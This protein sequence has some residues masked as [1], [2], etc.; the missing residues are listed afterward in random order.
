MHDQ[1]QLWALAAVIVVALMSGVVFTR[2][3]QPALVGYL[4]SGILLGPSCL[5]VVESR[6]H[7]TF[8]ADLG[9]LLLLFIVGMELSL[10]SFR[11]VWF[12]A[13]ATAVLQIVGAIGI[14]TLVSAGLGWPLGRTILLGFVV[15]ISSTAVVIKI[16]EDINLLRTQI[17]Q[18]TVSILIAQDLA[19]VPMLLIIGVLTGDDV[20][21]ELELGK[22]VLSIALLAGL[23]WYLSRR[24]RVRLPFSRVLAASTE[25]RPLYGVALCFG[26]AT[27]TGALG[28]SSVYGAFLAGLIVGNSNAR[29]TL[30]HSVKPIQ[31]ILVMVFFVSIGLLIDLTFVWDN[32]GPVLLILF[33]VTIGKTAM[34]IGVLLVLRQPWLHAAISGLLLAQIGEFSFLLGG[35]GLSSGLINND[36]FQ[37]V[38]TVT[39]FTL[40]VSP[41]WLAMARRMLRIAITRAATVEEIVNR[42]KTGGFWAFWRAAHDRPLPSGLAFR[43]FGK[44][45]STVHTDQAATPAQ[46]PRS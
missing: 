45:R 33:I 36:A 46:E 20:G 29:R 11:A 9:I 39:A 8:L 14:M 28:L 3:R 4:L 18:L 40:I 37:L 23:V 35:I 32:I 19:I 16:L 24:E 12:V 25:L 21:I 6:D 15:A 42:L 7:I 30:L 43:I 22:I 26:A 17:G 2:F 44:P 13:T 1:T 38:V 27:I 5:A 31:N 10:R 41:L 34:N